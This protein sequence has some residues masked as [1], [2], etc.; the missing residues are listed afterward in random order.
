MEDA[1]S[2]PYLCFL[3]VLT[4]LLA[5]C[6]GSGEGI[7]PSKEDR[8]TEPEGVLIAFAKGQVNSSRSSSAAA[9]PKRSV[10]S[11]CGS[12]TSL[13]TS[14]SQ[15]NSLTTLRPISPFQSVGGRSS[16]G[17]TSSSSHR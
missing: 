6:Y 5:G 12:R 3:P 4:L 15:A 9:S 11:E 10:Q 2:V 14:S 1:M 16:G 8:F 13:S 17:S 7:D